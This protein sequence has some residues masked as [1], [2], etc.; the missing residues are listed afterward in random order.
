MKELSTFDRLRF[1]TLRFIMDFCRQVVRHEKVNKMG[2]Y[3]MAITLAPVIFRTRH[4]FMEDI[5]SVGTHYDVMI[6][7]IENF[8]EIF[9][10]RESDTH[11]DGPKTVLKTLDDKLGAALGFDKE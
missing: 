2:S 3:N 8:N 6:R 11:L 7:M 10:G 1:N 5:M 9:D 4:L